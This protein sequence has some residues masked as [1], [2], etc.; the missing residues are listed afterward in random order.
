MQETNHR[1]HWIDIAKGICMIL[2]VLGHTMRGGPVWHAVYGFH[3][4]AFFFLTGM[5][6]GTGKIRTDIRR[7]LV[8]YYCFG[9]F[10]IAVFAVAGK[11]AASLYGI[12]ANTALMTNLVHLL[13]GNGADRAMLFNTALWFLP[14]LFLT[15][16]LYYGADRLCRGVQL[17]IL[18]VCA[19]LGI[20]GYLYTRY[21]LPT[22]PFSA[23][24]ALKMLPL[25]A[26][27]RFF[28]L[29]RWEIHSRRAG[30][31]LG[32]L[33]LAAACLLALRL[34]KVNYSDDLFPNMGGFCATALLGTGGV[35]LLSMGIGRNQVLEYLGRNTLAIMVMHKFPVVLLQM[36][37][38]FRGILQQNQTLAGHLMG[39]IPAVI[40]SIAVCLLAAQIIKTYVPVLLGGRKE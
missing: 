16:L 12:P 25:L 6:C 34:P 20:L 4:A 14:C 5:T 3:V 21:Q 7:I 27:G 30:L 28:R 23:S 19:T 35:L 39:G 2:V 40:L 1:I 33:L 24:V 29:Q 17:L 9:L 13:C 11:A 10:S 36:V 37:Q 31:A 38:P 8:P 32:I 18:T 15:K 26:L 22:L